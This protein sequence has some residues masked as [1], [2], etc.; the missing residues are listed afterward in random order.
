VPGTRLSRDGNESVLFVAAGH[1]LTP[2]VPPSSSCISL[3]LAPPD[4]RIRI[5]RLPLMQ[6][7]G[8]AGGG[9]GG[10]LTVARLREQRRA[11]PLSPPPPPPLPVKS[12]HVGPCGIFM[13]FITTWIIHWIMCHCQTMER[14][15]IGQ[16]HNSSQLLHEKSL[17]SFSLF[18]T[19]SFQ[20]A[21]RMR[22]HSQDTV[23]T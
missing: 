22:A 2:G 21:R 17:W 6:C 8:D 10:G 18:E 13:I 3:Q 16:R 12:G 19:V 7:C 11:C 23:D 20:S 5:R 1:R 4:S 9:A 15:Y 14:Q